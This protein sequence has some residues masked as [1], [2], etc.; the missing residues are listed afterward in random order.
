[1]I[2]TCHR[3]FPV[4]YWCLYHWLF[5]VPFLCLC[6]SLFSLF[7][8]AICNNY[9]KQN[10]A[11]FRNWH[12]SHF[13]TKKTARCLIGWNL[14]IFFFLV[15]NFNNN[16]EAKDIADVFLHFHKQKLAQ[17]ITGQCFSIESEATWKHWASARFGG[18]KTSQMALR[19]VLFQTLFIWTAAGTRCLQ[20]EKIM[21]QRG[22]TISPF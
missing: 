7:F 21:I 9:W 19:I 5:P 16:K 18:K 14:V 2:Q 13:T 8:Q 20:P 15:S 1:M 10:T 4:P 17:K 11:S 6:N 22:L 12:K 3:L